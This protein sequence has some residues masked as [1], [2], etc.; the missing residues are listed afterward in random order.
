VS[1]LEDQRSWIFLPTEVTCYVA[2]GKTFHK[3]LPA[4]IIAAEVPS[5]ETEIKTLKFNT[6]GQGARYIKIVAKNL[7]D[8]PKWHLG[9]PFKGKAWIFID[10]ITIK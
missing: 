9:S 1:F 6:G 4:Q 8:L 3:S 2:T 10:E 7:G 5:S